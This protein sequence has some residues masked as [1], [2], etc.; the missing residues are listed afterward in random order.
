MGAVF[1]QNTKTDDDKKR[2][3]DVAV[4]GIKLIF[5]GNLLAKEIGWSDEQSSERVRKISDAYREVV[6]S[7]RT[8]HNNMFHGFIEHDWKLCIDHEKKVN[9]SLP[10]K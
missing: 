9:A 7:N 10:K 4:R 6:L 2:G 5:I 8:T 3:M 1:S